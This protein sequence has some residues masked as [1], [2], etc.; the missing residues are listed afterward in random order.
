MAGG[1]FISF[2]GPDGG[3]KTTQIETLR[4]KLSA[5]GY[6]VIKTREIG[7]TPE[8][9]KIRDLV[10]RKSGG[11]WSPMAQ[12]LLAFTARLV[13]T[14]DL[15]K[16]ALAANKVVLSDRYADSTYVYQVAVP[17]L[18]RERYDELYRFTLGDFKPDLTIILDVDPELGTARAGRS[19]QVNVS[20]EEKADD[21]FEA[22]GATFQQQ[23]RNVYLDVAQ[24][25]PERCVVVDAG[26][27]VDQ[28]ADDVWKIVEQRMIAHG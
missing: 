21:R 20:R 10:V 5:K 4:T 9:E 27:P 14:E 24:R 28:V 18:P 25:N 15:I 19:V 22:Q 16:P 12:L 1:F 6:D 3:G 7:G 8:A 13:H 11:N 17:G 23:V 2:D 26:R